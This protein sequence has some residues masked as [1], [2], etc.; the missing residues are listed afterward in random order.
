MRLALRERHRALTGC[1]ARRTHQ[2]LAT[3]CRVDR[4][5]ERRPVQQHPRVRDHRALIVH[6]A[7]RQLRRA[8]PHGRA[9]HRG[10]L[11]PGRDVRAAGHEH[12][13]R[14][15]RGAPSLS[16]D[17]FEAIG[18]RGNVERPL[19]VRS[20]SCSHF[21]PRRPGRRATWRVP[22]RAPSRQSAAPRCL[23]R[24]RSRS[25][26]PG[27]PVAQRGAATCRHT[28]RKAPS[29]EPRRRRQSVSSIAIRMSAEA[30]ISAR[31][32]YGWK[33]STTRFWASSVALCSRSQSAARPSDAT[34]TRMLS[35]AA[36]A[37][38][39]ADEQP[40]VMLHPE[41][42]GVEK[43]RRLLQPVRCRPAILLRAEWQLLQWRP[44]IDHLRS[45]W[46]VWPEV[47]RNHHHSVRLAGV[48]VA[49]AACSARRRR[50]DENPMDA[51]DASQPHR[52]DPG[53]S[54]Q[55]RLRC[56]CRTR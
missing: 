33:G 2:Q 4:R 48:A 39:E 32:S 28:G 46:H 55:N 9:S 47:L 17:I 3:P 52:S 41:G 27:S 14:S 50:A 54:T 30:C 29:R 40:R 19:C 56:S 13:R 53:P 5:E 24:S 45:R 38:S 37:S 7:D 10:R 49:R 44:V 20:S 34:T 18:D 22:A 36:Q 11:A 42:A 31:S 25:A 1:R 8:A 15:Y 26:Q 51:V 12:G 6:D 43:I 16:K 23:P 21:R 35:S